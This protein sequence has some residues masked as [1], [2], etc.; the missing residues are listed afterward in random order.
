M[1]RNMLTNLILLVISVF[2]VL[3]LSEFLFFRFILRPSDILKLDFVNSVIKYAPNQ[4][5]IYRKASE[6]KAN[7]SINNNGWNSAH[8]HYDTKKDTGK[9]RIAVIGDSFVEA[10]QVS[11]NESFAEKLES[12]LGK[13]SFD[14]YRFGISGAP[15]S[16]YLHL[17]RKE[18]TQFKPDLLV[19]LLTHNDFVESFKKVDGVYTSCFLKIYIENGK[20]IGEI[21]PKKLDRK[22]YHF[23][24]EKS[25]IWRYFVYRKGIRFN[26][27]RK[28]ILGGTVTGNES[29]QA[30]IDITEIFDYIN[31][32]EVLTDYIFNEVKKYCYQK[33]ME[34]VIIMDGYRNII[35][36]GIDSKA[37]YDRGAL[38]L[39]K[40][41][42]KFC[43]KYDIKFIDLHKVFESDYKRNKQMF[44]FKNDAHWNGYGHQIASETLYKMIFFEKDKELK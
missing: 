1:K 3:L 17:I 41:A 33:K 43:T 8:T 10:L 26:N 11:F 14:V 15:L 22:W 24:R 27:L 42:H 36:Q 35:Y 16:Q 31:E 28:L 19:I 18:V 30:N 38:Q 40:I 6:I 13:D 5:G 12:K 37:Y 2:C 21:Q 25:A 32:I 20:V 29:Y 23:I 7:Y 39:N 44:N 9:Y 4:K 34:V